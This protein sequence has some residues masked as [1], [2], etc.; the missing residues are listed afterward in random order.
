[1]PLWDF[2]LFEKWQQAGCEQE[3]EEKIGK[4]AKE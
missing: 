3:P 2:A 4:A 1:M